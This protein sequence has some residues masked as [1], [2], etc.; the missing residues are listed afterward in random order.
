MEW[1]TPQ[2]LTAQV[3]RHWQRGRILS[4]RLTGEPIFP[5]S[6]RMKR[7]SASD[8]AAQF[9]EVRGWIRRLD[10]G[11]RT[12]RGF[13]Y[14][15]GWEEVAHRQLGR[16]R[17]PV[18]VTIPSES[19]ALAL[20]GREGAGA[21]FAALADQ[22]RAA[23]PQL[24]DWVARKS[25]TVI[26]ND[27]T[28]ERILLV[29]RWFQDHPRSGLYL[30][31]LDIAGVDTKFV[32]T[33]ASLLGDLLEIVLDRP[34]AAPAG[35]IFEQRFGLRPRPPLLRFRILDPQHALAGLTDITVPVA[36]FAALHLPLRR[37]FITENEIN[38]L[39]FPDVPDSIVI[40]KLGYAIELLAAVPW[41]PGC[42][43]HYW[44]DIDTHGFAMLNKLR[45]FCPHA[46]SLLMDRDTLLA[47]QPHWVREDIPN[48]TNLPRLTA[49]EC[50]LYVDLTA[51][52]F[53]DRIRL[54]Q[55]R[56]G[57]AR[58][59]MALEDALRRPEP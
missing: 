39:V 40:F 41:L 49:D 10:D 30:R 45:A 20:I 23:F 3:E 9:D 44:G 14:D 42:A 2:D 38:G 16:N 5:L 13:G 59:A 17:I 34:A 47:H 58:L 36:Q 43:I 7:P 4:A 29:L 25:L 35:S 37:V 50:A 26:D 18:S 19:D 55:E 28:W 12:R 11:C 52:T 32:E 54:E 48:T 56:V 24:Q 51:N 1:T 6:L 21:R 31:Q 8:M 53:G 33:H 15:I 57:F 27:G 22:T 46:R